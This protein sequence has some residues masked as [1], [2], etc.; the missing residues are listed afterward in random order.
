MESRNVVEDLRPQRKD[1]VIAAEGAS[2][3]LA[4]SRL[5]KTQ[6]NH[7]IAVCGEATCTQ[8]IENYLRYQEARDVWP[9]ETAN[10]VIVPM[11]EVLKK[12][13]ITDDAQRVAAWRLYAVFLTRAF[14]YRKAQRNTQRD[15]QTS[16]HQEKRDKAR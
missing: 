3:M 9:K 5:Q 13:E 7:L 8:E 16:A 10:Q 1:F 2:G 11:Q 12:H 4:A 6:L 14:T 15:G